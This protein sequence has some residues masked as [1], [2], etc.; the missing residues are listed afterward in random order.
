MLWAAGYDSTGG[1][2]SGID[3]L[4]IEVT[5]ACGKACWFCYNGSNPAAKGD[6][7]VD[8][9]EAFILDSVANGVKAVSLGGGEPLLW[10]GIFD[11]LGRLYG[12]CFRSVT[13]NGLQLDRR[14]DALVAAR[15]DKVHVSIHFPEDKAEVS[16]VI[17]QVTA[18]S[19]A[20]VPS[21]VNL[22][23]RASTLGPAK[24]VWSQLLDANINAD[25]VVVLPMRGF[26]TPSPQDLLK[27]TNGAL[28]QSMT[29]LLGCARSPRFVSVGA[30]QSVGWCSYTQSR[31][32]LRAP[33]YAALEEAL[34]CLPL[35]YCGDDTT[36]SNMVREQLNSATEMP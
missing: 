28:F 15:P 30:D 4:S 10:P 14:L 24:R 2:I 27:M 9:L 5:R 13:T 7:T 3:R 8:L 34:D 29:C 11:L 19:D 22:L 35:R 32:R 23:V 17:R 1:S 31:R 12:S 21:G 25:R 16:R 18:L 33:T 36:G 26:D 20:G 6:W